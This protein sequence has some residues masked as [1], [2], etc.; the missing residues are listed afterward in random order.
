MKKIITD[1][2]NAE[3]WLI[4]T[5]SIEAGKA[6]CNEIKERVANQTDVGYI[7]AKYAL[8]EDG[9]EIIDEIIKD[10]FTQKRILIATA[11]IDNV[12]SIKDEDLRNI[13]IMA[14]TDRI[15][16]MI[17]DNNGTFPNNNGGGRNAPKPRDDNQSS[18]GGSTD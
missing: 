18:D 9:Q 13:V 3:K 17:T 15:N 7:D 4:F 11:V 2:S 16:K 1:S 5:D 14:D 12:I 8:D 6:L 10:N